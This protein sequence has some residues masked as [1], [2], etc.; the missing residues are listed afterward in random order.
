[1]ATARTRA[2]VLGLDHGGLDNLTVAI[3]WPALAGESFRLIEAKNGDGV[4]PLVESRQPAHGIR[5]R[6][7]RPPGLDV[8]NFIGSKA[9]PATVTTRMDA[10]RP[11]RR[12]PHRDRRGRPGQAG[13]EDTADHALLNQVN[14]AVAAGCTRFIGLG[15][16]R[17]RRPISPGQHQATRHQRSAGHRDRRHTQ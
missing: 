15:K 6:T 16:H 10:P 5:R 4:T 7:G 9:R 14:R 3:A 12:A 2:V 17:I 8:E 13:R 11:T 1:M